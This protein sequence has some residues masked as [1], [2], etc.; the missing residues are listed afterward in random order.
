MLYHRDITFQ[1]V[2]ALLLAFATAAAC[3]LVGS[4]LYY[5]NVGFDFTDEAYYLNAIRHPWDQGA[6]VRLFGFLYY[7]FYVVTNGDIAFLR[8]LNIISLYGA[9]FLM[10]WSILRLR[11]Y[12][13]FSGPAAFAECFG[14]SLVFASGVFSY[15]QLWLPTP[16]YN[17][18][19][20]IGCL[21]VVASL[22][23][24]ERRHTGSYHWPWLLLGFAGWLIFMSKP[25]SAAFMGIVSL[26]F[27]WRH[28]RG[29]PCGLGAAVLSACLLLLA[30]SFLVAGSPSGFVHYINEA[31]AHEQSLGNYYQA[32]SLLRVDEFLRGLPQ[33]QKVTTSFSVACAV[34]ILL[35]LGTLR[36]AL[37]RASVCLLLVAGLLHAVAALFWDQSLLFIRLEYILIIALAVASF[38][39]VRFYSAVQAPV[40]SALCFFLM[41]S[42]PLL[43]AFGTS[44]NYWWQAS[45]AAVFWLAAPMCLLNPHM[46]RRITHGVCLCLSVVTLSVITHAVNYAMMQPY[47]QSEGI[48]HQSALF[49]FR[50]R[51]SVLLLSRNAYD[52]ATELKTVAEAA[53]FK[54]GDG[55]LDLTGTMPGG[56]YVLQARSLGAAWLVGLLYGSEN[57]GRLVL[58]KVSCAE[59]AKSWFLTHRSVDNNLLNKLTRH[60]GIDWQADL[61][62]AGA[63]KTSGYYWG[64]GYFLYKPSR[65]Y[66]EALA[67]CEAAPAQATP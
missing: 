6:A 20:L 22:A 66:H 59:F 2:G 55:L 14:F 3:A 60:R 48:R 42:V 45:L 8:Q 5:S 53:G 46:P 49:E 33:A 27:L 24:I 34:L 38:M 15:L 47:R 39:F 54:A 21:L 18:L 30:T 35:W 13:S 17:T 64:E 62:L 52:F 37:P 19:A 23:I 65:P 7:P 36:Q 43:Y 9:S 58:D 16:N 29:F 61:I 4:V 51:G 31:I 44:N 57:Y 28:K 67:A 56:A 25:P 1:R 32:S 10:F 40:R 12:H 50:P 41:A 63:L 26:L 11:V